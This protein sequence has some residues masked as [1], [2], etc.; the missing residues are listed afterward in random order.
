MLD[1]SIQT[2]SIR[3]LRPYQMKS[4]PTEGFEP[5]IVGLGR[6]CVIQLRYA[7]SMRHGFRPARLDGGFCCTLG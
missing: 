3:A 1:D 2:L 7:G 4:M 5:P 6:H